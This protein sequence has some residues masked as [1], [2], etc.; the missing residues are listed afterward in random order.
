METEKNQY[1]LDHSIGYKL[2]QG[3]RLMNTQLNRHFK[4]NGF[5]LSHEQWQ[6]LCRLYEMDGQTQNELAL[7]NERD[8]A[9]VSRLIDNMIKGKWVSR[10]P[11]KH[12]RRVNYIYLTEDAKGLRQELEDLAQKTISQALNNV[13]EEDLAVT[14]RTLDQMKENLS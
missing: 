1:S 2:F 8:Q 12:D 6:I 14:L 7:R 5:N 10:V 9:S 3:S 11:Q 4:T 13:S